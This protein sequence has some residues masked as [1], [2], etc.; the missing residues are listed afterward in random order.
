MVDIMDLED[1]G[2]YG[3]C[4]GYSG[5]GGYGGG[6]PGYGNQGVDLVVEEEDMV[7]IMKEESLVVV[8]TVM[9]FK[10]I[11]DSKNQILDQRRGQFFVEEA[12]AVPIV[13]VMDMVVDVGDM[14]AEGFKIKEK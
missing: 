4:P 3:G 2:N 7:V 8:G 14:V 11:V 10:I 12:Q 13:V 9:T 1:G 5:R 6:G